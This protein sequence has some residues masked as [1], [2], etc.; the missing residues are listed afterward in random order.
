MSSTNTDKGVIF[1]E[2]M[3]LG[4]WIITH[5]IYALEVKENQVGTEGVI[6]SDQGAVPAFFV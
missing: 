6:A 4:R 5:P 1:H 3:D 2:L